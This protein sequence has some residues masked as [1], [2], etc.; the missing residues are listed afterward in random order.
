[1]LPAPRVIAIDDELQHL[2]GLIQGLNQYGT[3]C[4]PVHFPDDLVSTPLCPH[5]RVI[6]ADLHLSGDIPID[7]TNDFGAI[8]GL[9]KERIK[10]SGPYLI[11]LWTRYSEQADGLHDFLKKDLQSVTKPFTV[12]PLDKNAHLD[13]EGAVKN[14]EKLVESIRRIVAK[15]PQIGALFN[16]EERVLEAA[17]DTASSITELAESAAKDAKPSKD[18]GRLIANL[19][20]AS[21]GEKHVGKDRFRAVNESLLPILGDRIAAM[22][23]RGDDNELWENALGK[24]AAGQELSQDEAARLNRLLHIATDGDG[25]ER[26]AVI[27]LPREFSGAAFAKTFDL[28]AEEAA[29]KQFLCKPTQEDADLQWV[30]VQTQAACDYAQTRPGPLPFHLGLCLPASEV[31]K[32]KPPAALWQSPYFKLKEQPCFLLVNA[33]FQMSLSSAKAKQAS[34]LFRLREQLLNNLIYQIHG[35]GARPGIISLGG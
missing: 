8:G 6:F 21:V 32:R 7:H 9:L 33:R 31:Q 35:Y 18:V 26:G 20:I 12:Q 17:A 27:A 28:T 2:E 10:P 11:I 15:Q 16:W 25:A 13:P 22:R 34:L 24:S 29:E 3:T 4:L 5:V 1:M 30:L 23:S 14:P 19:A